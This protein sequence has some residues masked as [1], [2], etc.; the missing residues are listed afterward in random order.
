MFLE[1]KIQDKIE[2]LNEKLQEGMNVTEIRAELGIGEK[3]LRKLFV[4]GVEKK[5]KL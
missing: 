1:M 5:Q 3:K 4:T 2:Y